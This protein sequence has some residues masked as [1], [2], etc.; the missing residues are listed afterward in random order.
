MSWFVLNHFNK[1]F[2]SHKRLKWDNVVQ[3]KVTAFGQAIFLH[4][5]LALKGSVL[6]KQVHWQ[7]RLCKVAVTYVMKSHTWQK[8]HPHK[9]L[10]RAQPLPL[11][12]LCN[13]FYTTYS[14]I[15]GVSGK[16]T[17]EGLGVVM[18]TSQKLWRHCYNTIFPKYW[19]AI[20]PPPPPP[21][22]ATPLSLMLFSLL[23]EILRTLLPCPRRSKSP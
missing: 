22:P 11:W 19:G 16:L 4:Y 1:Q 18:M 23:H 9:S 5:E 20:A 12:S 3:L 15:R 13:E 14:L 2:S 6:F 7:L 8:L 17:L 10:I 21:P